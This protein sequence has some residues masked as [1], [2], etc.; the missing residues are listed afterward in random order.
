MYDVSSSIN[1]GT[2]NLA[3]LV[4]VET[5]QLSN[6]TRYINMSLIHSGTAVSL[7]REIMTCATIWVNFKDP[8][9]SYMRPTQRLTSDSLYRKNSD[10]LIQRKAND[11]V[12][13]R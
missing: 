8:M 11:S 3:I 7:N 13:G 2:T 9:L 12:I 10:Q 5:A 1:H 6:M 4:L